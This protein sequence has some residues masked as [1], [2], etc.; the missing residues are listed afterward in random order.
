MTPRSIHDDPFEWMIEAINSTG[1]VER[2]AGS[3]NVAVAQAA[4]SEFLWHRDGET[5]RLRQ[6]G[7]IMREERAHGGYKERVIAE[8]ERRK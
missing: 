5:L 6:K 2:V 4:F 1:A 8:A 7:R 3:N